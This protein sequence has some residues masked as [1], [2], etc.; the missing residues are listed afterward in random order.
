MDLVGAGA[1]LVMAGVDGMDLVGAGAAITLDMD[2]PITDTVTAATD[3]MVITEV[4][5]DITAP[6]LMHL[7]II[8]PDFALTQAI[9][10]DRI[11]VREQIAVGPISAIADLRRQEILIG[12]VRQQGVE[13]SVLMRL[14]AT[15]H[16]DRAGARVLYPDITTVVEHIAPTAVPH[17]EATATEEDQAVLQIVPVVVPIGRTLRGGRLLTPGLVRHRA[18]ARDIA[19]RPGPQVLEVQDTEVQAAVPQEV[20]VSGVQVEVPEVPVA[21]E[22][23]A[24]VHLDH[25]AAGAPEA[26]CVPVE[27]VPVEEEEEDN[28]CIIRLI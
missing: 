26:E 8:R 6:V 19:D 23:P 7:P 2:I 22:V 10:L 3:V 4:E 16:T 5:E 13:E 17:P 25:L 20:Q 21:L 15:G 1:I 28:N 11:R 9:L 27:D 14:N 12:Q 18:E 24:A